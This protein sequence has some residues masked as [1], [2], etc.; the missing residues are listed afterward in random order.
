MSYVAVSRFWIG[1]IIFALF[2]LPK[3]D[4]GFNLL[5][6]NFKKIMIV[7]LIGICANSLLY[8]ITL[9]YLH[10]TL[11]MILENLAPVFVLI[12][13]FL[14]DK[15][16]PT[17]IQVISLIIA[18]IGL[19]T[20]VFGKGSF[21]ELGDG[22]Q[23]GIVLG[24][25]T[26][27]TFGGYIYFSADLLK[28]NKSNPYTVIKLLFWIFLISSVM[29][30]PIYFFIQG[31]IPTTSSEIFWFLEMGIF[32]SGISYLLWNFALTGISA[33]TASILFTF[34]VLF[35]TVNEALFLNLP[36]NRTLIIGGSLI[37]LAGYLLSR[38]DKE[39]VITQTAKQN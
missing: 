10:G 25:L 14:K 37:T 1:T 19:V 32:Q 34:T 24:I 12:A 16:L 18:M 28:D 23:L 21:P 30:S 35:T 17:K 11:V 8:H 13:V 36:I 4:Y 15:L 7:S 6:K 39:Q 38:K 31:R 20:I 26:G 3:K 33:S 29:M 9:K 27:I 5:K 22:Y 2:L